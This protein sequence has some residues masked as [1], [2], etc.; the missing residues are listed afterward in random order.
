MENDHTY[1]SVI[2]CWNF[3]MATYLYVLEV[4]SRK[5]EIKP[6]ETDS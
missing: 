6:A 4:L 3:E 2:F 1:K 5:T